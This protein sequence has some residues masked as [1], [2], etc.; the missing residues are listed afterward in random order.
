MQAN[1]DLVKLA[2]LLCKSNVKIRLKYIIYSERK[3]ITN[4]VS[5]KIGYRT[6]KIFGQKN[7]RTIMKG[8][9]AKINRN[10]SLLALST[11]MSVFTANLPVAHKIIPLTHD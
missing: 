3:D 11:Q 4:F 7:L 2:F 10:I 6:H 5:C 8:K 9:L 1:K